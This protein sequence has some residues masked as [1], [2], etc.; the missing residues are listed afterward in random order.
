MRLRLLLPFLVVLLGLGFLTPAEAVA[1]SVSI[2]ARGFSVA[3]QSV[4]FTVTANDGENNQ[5]YLFIE[6]AGFEP[7]VYPVSAAVT[8]LSEV[9]RFT[10]GVNT[11]ITA[12][13]G[14]AEEAVASDAVI[15]MVRPV[16]G[17]KIASRHGNYGK[18]ALLRRGAQPLFRSALAPKIAAGRCLRHE[19][20]RFRD[21]AWR[22]VA[23]SGCRSLTKDAQTGWTWKGSHPVGP[24]FRVR[25][26]FA[27]DQ[28][29]APGPGAWRYFRFR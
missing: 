20:Q 22:T 2:T 24:S 1:P 4:E 9:Y 19:V 13:L 5:L 14:P 6:Q 3:G 8:D 17:T 25:A 12:H 18:Y 26:T 7:K 11:K 10:L 16:I 21:G 15:V 27:G 23:G 28:V 29:N